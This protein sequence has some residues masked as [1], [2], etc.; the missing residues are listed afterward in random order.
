MVDEEIYPDDWE[1]HGGAKKT[2]VELAAG[3]LQRQ[4]LST[5]ALDCGAIRAQ[6]AR[7][8][9]WRGG[10]VRD[11]AV[12]GAGIYQKTPARLLIQ[13]VKQ[14]SGGGGVEPRRAD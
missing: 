11:D 2:P 14:L 6:Q 9:R 13:S 4:L 3:Q 7:S 10:D 8:R 12:R 5:P 1:R